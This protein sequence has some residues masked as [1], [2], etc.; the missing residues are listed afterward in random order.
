MGEKTKGLPKDHEKKKK[1]KPKDDDFS[2]K[3]IPFSRSGAC[4]CMLL[5]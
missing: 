1:K 3:K 4:G 5:C 2:E